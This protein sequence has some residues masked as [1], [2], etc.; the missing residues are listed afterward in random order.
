MELT[1]VPALPGF[2][3]QQHYSLYCSCLTEM[4]IGPSS[5]PANICSQYEKETDCLS[6][7]IPFSKLKV[8]VAKSDWTNI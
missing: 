7:S 3:S 1:I 5:Y 4:E 8:T 6:V 2:R